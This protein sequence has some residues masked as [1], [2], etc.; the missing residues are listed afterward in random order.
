MKQPNIN[1]ALYLRLSRDDENYG[2]SVSIETQRTILRQYA[3]EN[4]FIDGARDVDD[5][6]KNIKDRIDDISS[7][8]KGESE[9]QS[10]NSIKNTSVLNTIFTLKTEKLEGEQENKIINLRTQM[11]NIQL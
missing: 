11:Q 2:D 9:Y 5:G 10:F 7:S 3:K 1:A 6:V 8:G 4:G